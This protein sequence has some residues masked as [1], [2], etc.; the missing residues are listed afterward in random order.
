MLWII[1]FLVGGTQM[2][3]CYKDFDVITVHF[4]D[5]TW[6]FYKWHK[7]AYLNLIYTPVMSSR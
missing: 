3:R 2:F 7:L 6:L 5:K 4:A 1:R